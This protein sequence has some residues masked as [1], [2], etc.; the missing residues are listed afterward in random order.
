MRLLFFRNGFRSDLDE[1]V[2]IH[3]RF[4]T[5][6]RTPVSITSGPRPGTNTQ[7][8]KLAAQSDA[9]E[10]LVHW[11]KNTHK[12]KPAVFWS[13]VAYSADSVT[14]RLVPRVRLFR[15]SQSKV[16]FLRTCGRKV[17]RQ[18]A[19]RCHAAAFTVTATAA[20]ALPLTES[21]PRDASGR[22]GE[23]GVCRGAVEGE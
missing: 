5:D 8:E 13:L 10:K 6:E 23:E 18:P 16:P 3:C 7:T 17:T 20:A 14:M 4:Q 15:A 19:E 1:G 2:I 9:N 21:V 11:H 12:K 22:E